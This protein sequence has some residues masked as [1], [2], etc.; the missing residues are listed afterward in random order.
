MFDGQNPWRSGAEIIES[1]GVEGTFKAI[2]SMG[3][4]S[5]G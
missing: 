4:D 1:L 5:F 2:L 3:R